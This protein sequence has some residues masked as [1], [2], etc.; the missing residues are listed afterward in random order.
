MNIRK[1]SVQDASIA[2]ELACLLWADNSRNEMETEFEELLAK[3]D[4]AIFLVEGEGEAIGF[5]Q[6]QLRRDY[7]E[8][9]VSS[10]RLP[11]GY[12][13]PGRISETGHGKIP[14][15]SL[16]SLGRGAALH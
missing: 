14:A 1:A 13:R 16:R 2:A 8:G 9:T 3:E 10:R 11:G 6:C 5:A 15:E 12:F 7:V 4:A